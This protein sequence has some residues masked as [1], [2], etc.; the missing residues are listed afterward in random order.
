MATKNSIS[1]DIE[2]LEEILDG[3]SDK[4]PQTGMVLEKIKNIQLELHSLR[5]E[6]ERIKLVEY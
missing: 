4:I 1:E 3:I 6:L 2:N 5:K